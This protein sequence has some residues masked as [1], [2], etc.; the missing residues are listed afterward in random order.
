MNQKAPPSLQ[1][2]RAGGGFLDKPSSLTGREA[3]PAQV[4]TFCSRSPI[5]AV[6]QLLLPRTWRSPAMPAPS[7]M[8]IGARTAQGDS[9]SPLAPVT[10]SKLGGGTLDAA[11][12]R[13]APPAGVPP[14]AGVPPPAP[15]VSPPAG[16]CPPPVA[17]AVVGTVGVPPPAPAVSPPVTA[18]GVPPP[19]LAAS[20]PVGACPPPVAAAGVGAVGVPPP[21]PAVSPPVGACPPPVAAAVVGA[22]GIPPAVSPPVAAAG[23]P[24]PVP[25]ASPPVGACSPPV[26][27]AAVAG[28]GGAGVS[29]GW[30]VAVTVAGSVAVGCGGTA[31][32]ASVGV[33]AWA[34]PPGAGVITNGRAATPP[35][36]MTASVMRIP[37]FFFLTSSSVRS[38]SNTAIL[39]APN[40]GPG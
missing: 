3:T 18:A 32:T 5:S 26:A 12:V 38:G 40:R 11:G 33:S 39:A 37:R 10:G 29:V 22:V 16:A 30:V 9:A 34:I 15:A 36:R 27:V 14:T 2:C 35:T 19:V 17:A 28:S 8:R 21:V 4:I 31:V 6:G 23:V 1:D 13:D 24:P 7:K 20:P 25:A